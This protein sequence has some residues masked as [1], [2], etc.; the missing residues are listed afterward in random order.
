M[1]KAS[2]AIF[3]NKSEHTK[4]ESCPDIPNEVF[5]AAKRVMSGPEGSPQCELVKAR[6]GIYLVHHSDHGPFT[7]HQ[8][9]EW[10]PV[11][12]MRLEQWS[13]GGIKSIEMGNYDLEQSTT[14]TTTT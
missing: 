10:L 1:P 4:H 5:E 8:S 14:D 6:N 7:D 13:S 12:I 9:D 2:I 3:Q 11:R